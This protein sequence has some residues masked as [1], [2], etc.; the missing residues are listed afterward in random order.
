[1]ELLNIKDSKIK[2]SS[3]MTEESFAKTRY[4]SLITQKGL[5]AQAENA[6][7]AAKADFTFTE[8]SFSSIKSE[9]D[10]VFFEGEFDFLGKNAE[11]T[12]LAEILDSSESNAKLTTANAVCRAIMQAA[13]GGK[14]VPLNGG[15]ILIAKEDGKITIIFLP[16]TIFYNCT[17]AAGEKK[18][19]KYLGLWNNK[20]LEG[21]AALCFMQA[22]IIYKALTA[23]FPFAAENQDERT[24]DI[25]DQNFL[26]IEYAVNG[27]SQEAAFAINKA[28]TVKKEN[29]HLIKADFLKELLNALEGT[30]LKAKD[31]ALS[32]KEFTER[33]EEYIRTKKAKIEAKRRFRKNS[34]KISA[35]AVCIFIVWLFT[36]SIVK[37]NLAQPT[38]IGLSPVQVTECFFQSINEKDVQLMMAASKGTPFK[39][40]L[41]AI[42]NMH[43]ADAAS[44]AYTFTSAN[45]KPEKWFFYAKDK[46][47]DANTSIWGISNLQIDGY[48]SI[49]DAEPTIKK[50]RPT[51]YKN[52]EGIVN[53]SSITQNV[54][55]YI[56]QTNSDT[57]EIEVEYTSGTI[58]LTWLKNRWILTNIDVK[59]EAMPFN[60]QEFKSE[61]HESISR[62][63]GDVI[64]ACNELSFRYAWIPASIVLQNEEQRL[65]AGAF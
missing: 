36:Q 15:G 53:N 7:G 47:S 41:T 20:L 22:V 28:L 3:G 21:T 4:S 13:A 63:N 31:S 37:S 9:E 8:W 42:T 64:K 16:E 40:Y 29:Q 17:V 6:T 52:E 45:L 30:V 46:I 24:A 23:Q 11:I 5:V 59:A 35:A 1:M 65:K 26:P 32:Q 34:T 18:L 44:Q 39:S 33:A 10:I 61:Y 54:S 58:T 38:T 48:K 2:L 57:A 56:V 49:L 62:N 14:Q 60:T 43:V 25:I 55:Y 27:I 51:I 50:N 12:P 19:T